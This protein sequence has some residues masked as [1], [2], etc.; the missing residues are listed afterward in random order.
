LP[1]DFFRMLFTTICPSLSAEAGAPVPLAQVDESRKVHL[2]VQG[3]SISPALVR[4]L[5]HALHA[6]N[7]TVRLAPGAAHAD[8]FRLGDVETGGAAR[9][10]VEKLLDGERVD[11]GFVP[12]GRSIDRVWLATYDPSLL[13]GKEGRGQAVPGARSLMATLEPFA[14]QMLARSERRYAPATQA[15]RLVRGLPAP[16]AEPRFEVM[17]HCRT[18]KV[19]SHLLDQLRATLPPEAI[20]LSLHHAEADPLHRRGASAGDVRIC[21]RPRGHTTADIQLQ[22]TGLDG[23]PNF[24]LPSSGRT[25]STAGEDWIGCSRRRRADLMFAAL[26]APLTG[27]AIAGG[28]A[29]LKAENEVSTM[30]YSQERVGHA[31]LLFKLFKLR[32]MRGPATAEPSAGSQDDRATRAGRAVRKYTVDELVTFGNVLKGNMTVFGIRPL[33]MQDILQ[34]RQVLGERYFAAWYRAYQRSLPGVYSIFGNASPFMEPHSEEFY[35]ARAEMDIWQYENAGPDLAREGIR[36]V[37][38]IGL[39]RIRDRSQLIGFR[40]IVLAA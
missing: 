13:G 35:F 32:T 21:Y 12:G 28:A 37:I 31:G 15:L 40:E 39:G 38:D 4:R 25:L 27:L 24:F 36:E 16:K 8:A 11:F 18:P 9:Y 1:L 34:M 7:G 29:A 6:K 3:P 17:S 20:E 26:T 30:F 33:V 23:V 14:Q 19:D 22:H 5:E 10:R 2:V